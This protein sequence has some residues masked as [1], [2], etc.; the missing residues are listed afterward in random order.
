MLSHSDMLC[1]PSFGHTVKKRHV[2]LDGPEECCRTR[3]FDWKNGE[4]AGEIQHRLG[5]ISAADPNALA[6]CKPT[7]CTYGITDY[8]SESKRRGILAML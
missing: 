1:R 5:G 8:G 6:V 7:I 2:Y 4:R 3:L